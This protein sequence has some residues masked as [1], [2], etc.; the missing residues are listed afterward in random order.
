M[1]NCA[2][3]IVTLF[4]VATG[5]YAQMESW[6]I[7]P[8][9]RVDDVNPIIKPDESSVFYCPIQDKVVHWECDHTFNPAA[10][11]YNGK[12]YLFYR[13]EDDFGQGIGHHT[14]RLGIAESEDGVHFVRNP[15]PVLY[16]DLDSQRSFEW[17]GGCEDPRIVQREDGTY[18]MTYTQW[19][20]FNKG[21]PNVARNIPLLGIATSTD[22]HHWE[23]R[24]YAFANSRIGRFHSKSGSIVCK[25]VG[26]SLIA[27]KIKDKYWMYW[28][29]GPVFG[30]TSDDLIAWDPIVDEYGTLLPVLDK[31]LGKFDS[32]LVEAGP[33]ALVTD[34]GILLIYN[35]KNAAV[36]G[37][38][39]ISIGAYAAGQVLFDLDDPTRTIER[40]EE[41]FFKPERE[42]EKTG[43][44]KNGTV[45]VEGL[46]PFHG[47]WLLY[48]GTADS[49]VGV[50]I[51]ETME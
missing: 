22:L 31:R 1:R 6:Q 8:F 46:V 7:G 48:Y 13:A 19:T 35:G 16:P 47:R 45:F 30:A 28:G 11:V 44:Y 50:A 41:S 42:Y 51:Y 14:S 49:A 20:Y 32:R 36:D 27:A 3:S 5:G 25:R 34:K 33:P 40:S 15:E 37:D 39:T 21:V 12:V 26:D 9:T 4:L 38:P 10:V 2:L 29:E 24:G 43:Q 17:P 18:I 23:K